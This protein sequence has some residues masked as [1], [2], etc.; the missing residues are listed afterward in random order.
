MSV[1]VVHNWNLLLVEEALAICIWY[2]NS[3]AHGYKL[4]ADYCQNYDPSYGTSLNGSSRTKLLEMARFM[5]AVE[6]HEFENSD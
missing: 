1:R 6:A 4:A 2:H 3:P 5:L